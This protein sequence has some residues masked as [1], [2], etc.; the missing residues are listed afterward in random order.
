[1]V[2]GLLVYKGMIGSM[3]LEI[4]G[5]HIVTW[6]VEESPAKKKDF[7][8]IPKNFAEDDSNP[9]HRISL[10]EKYGINTQI[11]IQI[12]PVL[13]DLSADEAKQICRMSNDDIGRIAC[14]YPD[15][16]IPFSVVSLL[17]DDQAVIEPERSVALW[18][19]GAYEAFRMAIW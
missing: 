8:L 12:T 14:Q 3:I 17:R 5:N 4:G 19:W 10:M 6:R 1:M 2:V 7:K 15:H 16:F 18:R 13:Q 11:L 9:E